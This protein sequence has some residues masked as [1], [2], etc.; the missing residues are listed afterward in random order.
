V[1]F[2]VEFLF[3]DKIFTMLHFHPKVLTLVISFLSAALS[4]YGQT[5]PFETD[6][7][8]T[9]ALKG[10][11]R[12]V[13]ETS[14]KA[15]ITGSDTVRIGKGWEYSWETDTESLFDTLGH[16]I[17]KKELIGDSWSPTGYFIYEGDKL[18]ETDFFGKHAT[19]LYDKLGQ[20]SSIR[21]ITEKLQE[22]PLTTNFTCF[23]ADRQLVKRVET[24]KAGII[25][26]TELFTYDAQKRLTVYQLKYEDIIET[27]SYVYSADGLAKLTWR[28]NEEGLLE[29]TEYS[30]TAGQLTKEH[31]VNY[32][33]GISQGF[34]DY[35]YENGNEIAVDDIEADGT[36][37]SQEK[38]TYSNYD[39]AGNWL[40]RVQ[41][42]DGRQV[43]IVER[44]ISYY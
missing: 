16:L 1:N 42:V 30:Y 17:E 9:L 26:G 22:A 10:A 19:F 13:K 24:D 31:W 11:V 41:V 28:D 34:V 15:Q 23:Y 35:F 37:V 21:L 6:D 27:T 3:L 2:K 44:E 14:F 20:V 5:P 12:S 18:M 38:S 8:S 40:K 25:K 43:F 7:L 4:I 33:E 32:E 39:K 36:V 29:E